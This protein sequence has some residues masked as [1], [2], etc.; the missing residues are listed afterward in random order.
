MTKER[1]IAYEPHPVSPE[2]KAELRKAGYKII[3]AR[4]DPDA[5]PTPAS[6]EVTAGIGTDSGDQFSDDQLRAVIKEAT[7]KA[8]HHKLGRDK[9]IEQFN[10][11]NA[12]AQQEETAS[13]G[14]TRREIEADLTAMEVEFDPKD[15]IEDLAALRDLTREE[16]NK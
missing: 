14:L 7:G 8:P 1:E 5:K 2:R 12:A 15:A 16:R 9:L 4:F 3:D 11:L 10:A 13:N 6:G